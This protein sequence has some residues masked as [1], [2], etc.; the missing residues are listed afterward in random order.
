MITLAGLSHHTAPLDIRE[1]LAV[2]EDAVVPLL[3]S[4]NARF[5]RGAALLAT[6]NRLE[7]YVGGEQD[8][9][10]VRSF[11]AEQLHTDLATLDRHVRVERDDAAVKHLYG[12]ASGID[13]MVLGETEVLGQVRTAFSTTVRAKTDDVVI[14]RLFHTALR[15]GRRVRA[16]TSISTGALSV[17]YIAAQQARALFPEIASATVLVIGAGEAGRLAAQAMVAQGARDVVVTNRTAERAQGLAAEFGGRSVPFEALGEALRSAHI[18][19]G[20][21]GAPDA[22]VT[23]EML[24]EAMSYR[25]GE[26]LLIVDIG[27]P[28]DFESDVRHLHG[29]EYYDVDDLRTVADRNTEA[30]W[31]EVEAVQA[32]VDEEAAKFYEWSASLRVQPTIAAIGAQAEAYRQATMARVLRQVPRDDARRAEFEALADTVT[33][34][35]VRQILGDPITVLRERGDLNF[36]L[37]AARALFRLDPPSDQ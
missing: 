8:A 3:Q 33:R 26:P 12:V 34:A 18:V 1:R 9:V 27:V 23:V 36:T 19:I 29:V 15:T 21:S 7:L 30:R 24:R 6:C 25:D 11:L 4:A 31:A 16:E 5:G 20:A 35:L 14:S 37:E 10:E 28:R 13:S 2:P 32:I 22:L 17:S